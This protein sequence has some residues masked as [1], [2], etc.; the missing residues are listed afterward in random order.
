MMIWGDTRCRWLVAMKKL[1]PALSEFTVVLV[2]RISR[3][4]KIAAPPI[5]GK[6]A[7]FENHTRVRHPLYVPGLALIG[8]QAA[9]HA[10]PGG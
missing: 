1:A 10:A 7:P 5:C 9:G 3:Q 6:T 8:N 4:I 2:L